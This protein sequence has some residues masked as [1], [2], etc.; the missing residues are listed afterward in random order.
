M[1]KYFAYIIG[2][3]FAFNLN[4]QNSKLYIN[5]C[6]E[7][8]KYI[9]R[10][11]PCAQY[12]TSSMCKQEV[13]SA[14]SL[15]I[16]LYNRI[17]DLSDLMEM[18]AE[19][20]KAGGL[21]YEDNSL[22]ILHVRKYGFNRLNGNLRSFISLSYINGVCLYNSMELSTTS[23]ALCLD[24]ATKTQYEVNSIDFVYLKKYVLPIADFP[25]EI[26]ESSTVVNSTCSHHAIDPKLLDSLKK[27][28]P[29]YKWFSSCLKTS[30]DTSWYIKAIWANSLGYGHSFVDPGIAYF[31]KKQEMD[32]LCD[33]LF[34]PNHT[35]A[36]NA[37][38]GLEYLSR[39]KGIR[40]SQKISYQ[41]KNLKEK[42]VEG[43]LFSPYQNLSNVKTYGELR[44]KAEEIDFKFSAAERI[45]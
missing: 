18:V 4:A 42:Q 16:K 26:F 37:M 41:I 6:A 11:M 35:T 10:Q 20:D 21:L 24:S 19:I 28:E 12:L 39:N 33:L 32:V 31:V 8:D 15:V 1:K 36:L 38:E 17:H 23:G 2:F 30:L 44:V 13:I 22:G 7:L 29:G 9:S 27:H 40:L 43:Y 45:I 5:N 14:D 34:S 3:L 25:L